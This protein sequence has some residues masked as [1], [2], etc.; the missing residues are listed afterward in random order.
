M[1]E[2]LHADLLKQEQQESLCITRQGT[3]P[4]AAPLH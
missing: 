4:G 2:W 3:K 1:S